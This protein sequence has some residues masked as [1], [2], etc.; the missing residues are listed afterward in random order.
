MAAVGPIMKAEVAAATRIGIPQNE[1][2]TGTWM[3]PP[4]DTEQAGDG[5]RD[6][7]H[8]HSDRQ[9]FHPVAEGSSFLFDASTQPSDVDG[10]VVDHVAGPGTYGDDDR[11]HEER[12]RE[13]REEIPR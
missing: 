6:D 12:D 4:P 13:D 7:R 5:A 1:L 2:R 11:D 9:A 3:T 10:V 8:R